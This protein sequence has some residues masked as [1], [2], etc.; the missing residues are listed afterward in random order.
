MSEATAVRV[1]WSFWVVGAA[2]LLFNLLGCINFASQMNAET[3][4]S[5]PEVYR[6]MVEIRPAWGTVAFALAVFGG[7]LGCLLLLFRKSIAFYVL[8]ASVIGAVFAQVP[9]LG[10]PDF[11]VEA[12]VGWLSQVAI[13]SF[14]VWYSTFAK[15]RNWVS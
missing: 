7:L 12:W 3:L 14:L 13:N 8:V 15:G 1:Q 4:A 6:R 2:G 5:M 11:P 10:M 9:F